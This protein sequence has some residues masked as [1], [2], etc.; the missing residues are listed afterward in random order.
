ME[1]SSLFLFGG[2]L[3]VR[4]GGVRF[5]ALARN[6]GSGG[7]GMCR[8]ESGGGPSERHSAPQAILEI[9][10]NYYTFRHTQR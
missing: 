9:Y 2:H 4:H 6:A 7:G 5:A 3:E 10:N 1:F 8:M